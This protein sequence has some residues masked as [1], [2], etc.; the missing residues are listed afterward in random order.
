MNFIKNNKLIILICIV[1]FFL[2]FYAITNYGYGNEYYASAVLS[3][4]KNFKNFFFVSF[5]PSGM[6]SVDKPP[7][8]LWIQAIS[9][10][11]FGYKGWA[12][13]LPQ[14][15]SGTISCLLIYILTKK[16]F[17]K[18]SALISSLIFA[19]T[20]IVVAVSRNNTID[21]QLIL[22]LLIAIL[23][24]FKS[25]EENKL[26][27]LII[28]GIFIGLGF[29]IKMLQA[30]MVVPAFVLTYLIFTKEK[31]SKKFINGIIATIIMVTISL[32]WAIAVQ[33]Y[34]SSNRPYVD[35]TSNNSVFE[36]IVGHNGIE[37]ILG[38]NNGNSNSAKNENSEMGSIPY[39]ESKISEESL[40]NAPSKQDSKK[41]ART[42]SVSDD[43]IGTASPLRLW[44]P[45]IYGQISWLLTMV[46]A[47]IISLTKKLK[48]KASTMKDAAIIFWEI[49]FFTMFIFFSFAGFY[50]R[51][52]LS[53]MAPSISILCG[54]GILKM[55]TDFKSKSS[56][57]QFI[58]PVAF[59]LTMILEIK[60]LLLYDDLPAILKPIIFI[61]T[62]VCIVFM[63]LHYLKKDIFKYKIKIM[64][65]TLFISLLT[66]PFYW[67]LTPVIYVPSLVKPAAGPDIVASET[68]DTKSGSISLSED[69]Q[70]E[71]YLLKN[72]KEGS[73]LVVAKRSNDVAR[74]IIDTGLPSYAYG[75][76][77]GSDNSLTLDKLKEYV[78]EGKITYFL[79]SDQDKEASE[80][81]DY[82]KEHATLVDMSEYSTKYSK[83]MNN[84]KSNKELYYFNNAK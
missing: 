75:G 11:I 54:I 34:P 77:L 17:N 3:M 60:N 6:V 71:Q 84:K 42:G 45:S 48:T 55:I 78:E 40:Y 57:K 37:R 38:R 46:F 28:A 19:I 72:Y 70:L 59:I 8:G 69:F 10:L 29:N 43:Y 22:V 74:F 30:Y 7:L 51:Y 2:N 64:S 36:L 24:L 44:I 76:F 82:V 73:F 9:V 58:L 62:F 18:T 14:A 63:I 67:A 15:L 25:I 49:Y 32:S 1:S 41:T 61:S 80:I 16:Y 31:F 21:M 35:S 26:I 23:F 50:H 83:V 13:L 4:T 27:Y 81:T 68:K 5:D 47:S 79:I 52:Y 12:L 53:M 20:P 33:L 39:K 56:W 66:A 65:I